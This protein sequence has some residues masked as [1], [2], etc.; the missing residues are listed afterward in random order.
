M[1][2][3]LREKKRGKAVEEDQSPLFDR[4]LT[5]ESRVKALERE[6]DEQHDFIRRLAARRFKEEATEKGRELTRRVIGS[7]EEEEP[8]TESKADLRRRA[9]SLLRPGGRTS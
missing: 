5:L 4:L 7:A 9:L 3:F 8:S 1:F 2:S 6:L